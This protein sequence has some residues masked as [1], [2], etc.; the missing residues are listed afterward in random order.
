MEIQMK[1]IALPVLFLFTLAIQTYAQQFS[2]AIEDNSYFI[3]EAFNQED[4][5]I[6]HIFNAYYDKSKKDFVST[7][8]QEWPAP[9][10]DHQLSFTI[11]YLSLNGGANGIGDILLNYRY[12]LWNGN[13][14]GWM[15]PRLS[16]IIPTGS[17]SKGLGD[18]VIGLQVNIPLSKRWTNE[19][20]SHFNAGT[21]VLPN[22]KEVFGTTEYKKTLSSYFIG[23]SGIF[24]LHENFNVMLEALYNYD[25]EINSS[26]NISRAG[27]AI[28]CPGIRYAINIGNL[29]IVPG[30]AFPIQFTSSSTSLQLFGYISF[31]H[32][33]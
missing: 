29:Q 23:A 6:Q 27:A 15:S 9:S 20:V 19:F 25:S 13:N 30:F 4:G 7:F 26:G 22:K 24:L 12:Q 21:T 32:P 18:N 2:K 10:Q 33:Y 28:V 14:W 3:E 11:P 5:V 31:E 17:S 8:T 1:K 16:F